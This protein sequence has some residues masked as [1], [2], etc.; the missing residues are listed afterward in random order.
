MTNHMEKSNRNPICRMKTKK[1]DFLVTDSLLSP[2]IGRN[3]SPIKV[4]PVLSEIKLNF[5]TVLAIMFYPS[6]KDHI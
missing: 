4:S 6:L 2:C 1:K 5:N 3:V